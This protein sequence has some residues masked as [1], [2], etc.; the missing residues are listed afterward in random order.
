ML[1]AKDF[2]NAFNRHAVKQSDIVSWGL[3][4]TKK[5]VSTK[6][7]KIIFCPKIINESLYIHLKSIPYDVIKPDDHHVY[8][9]LSNKFIFIVKSRSVTFRSAHALKIVDGGD[10]VIQ[11]GQTI[12]LLNIAPCKTKGEIAILN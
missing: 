10:Y 4:N 7:G 1:T 11:P 12:Q 9:N 2:A 6:E 8:A 3:F 5:F